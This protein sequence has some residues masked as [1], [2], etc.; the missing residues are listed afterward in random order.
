MSPGPGAL[1]NQTLSTQ[2]GLDSR[3]CVEGAAP[4][5]CTTRFPVTEW[6]AKAWVCSKP[7]EARG[8]G[9]QGL[10][11]AA[12]H[13]EPGSGIE[14]ITSHDTLALTWKGLEDSAEGPSGLTPNVSPPQGI[15]WH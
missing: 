14:Q 3:S 15:K 5:D 13:R 4:G 9:C 11:Y 6:G 10:G 12:N 8:E 7:P 2:Q 1:E